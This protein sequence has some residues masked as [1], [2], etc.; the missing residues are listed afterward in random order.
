MKLIPEQIL[1]LHDE[2]RRG[3]KRLKDYGAYFDD[4]API[5]G[6]NTFRSQVG[7]YFTDATFLAERKNLSEYEKI[8]EASDILHERCFDHV[9]IGTKFRASFV[10]DPEDSVEL[11]L[12][13]SRVGGKNDDDF[14]S[15]ES[16]FGQ[17]VLGAKEGDIVSYQV[18]R[19]VI[20]IKI[21]KI[22][23]DKKDYA[24][25]L[26]D[27][28][29]GRR[30]CESS[31]KE[32]KNAIQTS[33][34]EYAKRLELSVSQ[35]TM[36][37]EELRRIET[38]A[39]SVRDEASYFRAKAIR[40]YLDKCGCAFPTEDG[41]IGIGSRFDL[42]LYTKDGEVKRN[43]ELIN[44]AVGDE[45]VDEYVER[46]SPL[47]LQLYGLREGDSFKFRQGNIF[48]V[49]CVH[50]IENVSIDAYRNVS[51]KTYTKK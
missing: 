15:C 21:E 6:D 4:L 18:P 32:I 28:P 22:F 24:A 34:E 7:D 11:F 27:R 20:Q 43:V 51:G 25:F 8:L 40:Y 17:A 35:R 33:P 36:L 13:E 5:D 30:I 41:T 23:T 10:D 26:R 45:L 42:V 38:T 37:L 48:V 14:V 44:R 49:G 46:I 12:V 16:P 19:G 50:N 31:Q 39:D 1:H 29:Y 2:I 9:D 47:G 3:R